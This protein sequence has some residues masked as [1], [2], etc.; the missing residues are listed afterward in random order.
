VFNLIV[1]L[2][3]LALRSIIL[4]RA[5]QTRVVRGYAF[6]FLY[7]FTTCIGDVLLYLAWVSHPALYQKTYWAMQFLTLAIGCGIVLEIFRHVLDPYPGSAKFAS[8]VVLVTFGAVFFFA[9]LYQIAAPN[10]ALQRGTAVE[11]ERD[12]R[13]IQAIFLFGVFAVISYYRIPIGKN[14]KG[15]IAGY[16]LYI[17]TS[18][19]VLALRAYDARR[20]FERTWSVSQ[21]VSYDVSLLIWLIAL[22]SYFP[23]PVPDASIHLEQDYEALAAR[24]KRTL[25]AMRS[26]LARA[27][28]P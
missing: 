15:M 14:L 19:A 23:N 22:W 6:F 13:T 9:L 12:V 24:T 25:V 26:H 1:W 5:V 28:R 20:V 7:V 10:W 8:V 3:G 16:G 17:G 11:L 2:V 21:Q 27:A 4:F 18:L